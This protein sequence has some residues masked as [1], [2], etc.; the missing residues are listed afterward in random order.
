MVGW[1]AL[2]PARWKLYALLAASFVFGV[3]G[4]RAYWVEVAL[5]REEAKRNSARLRA[6]NEAKEVRR[7]VETLDDSGLVDRASRWLR[8][9]P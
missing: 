8:K 5:S 2:I 4:I 1:L 9:K 3:F 7:D 6:I